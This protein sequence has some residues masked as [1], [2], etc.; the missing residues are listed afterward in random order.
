MRSFSREIISGTLKALS[1][2]KNLK[3]LWWTFLLFFARLYLWIV[4]FWDQRII[5]PGFEEMWK[6]VE[7]TK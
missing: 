4:I 6:R 3:E 2:P 1:Y 7:S 5:K